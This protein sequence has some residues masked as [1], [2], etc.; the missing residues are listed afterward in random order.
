[1]APWRFYSKELAVKSLSDWPEAGFKYSRC[2]LWLCWHSLLALIL[3][4]TQSQCLGWRVCVCLVV[5]LSNL[6]VCKSLEQKDFLLYL[7]LSFCLF[8]FPFEH[9]FITK[10]HFILDEEIWWFYWILKILKIWNVTETAYC[11]SRYYIW[12]ETCFMLI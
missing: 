5:I 9:L 10:N 11:L 6:E 4:P 8:S 12:F 1:M 3:C 7:L 2:V